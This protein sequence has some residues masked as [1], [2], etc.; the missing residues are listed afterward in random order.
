[1]LFGLSTTS[2]VALACMGGFFILFSLVSSFVLPARDP[3]IP[4]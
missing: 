2:K 4:G 1:M 3:D